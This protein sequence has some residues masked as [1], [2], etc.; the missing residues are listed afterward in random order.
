MYDICIIGAGQSGLVT[1]KTFSEQTQN[2]I[3][4]E[5]CNDCTGMF[6]T[7]KE[8]NY[9]KWSTSRSM[10]G[11]SDYPMDK[12]LPNWFTIKDYVNYLQSYK[13]HFNLD[14]HIQYNSEVLSCKQNENE[15]WIVK[16]MYNR[17]ERKL[18]CKKLI[19]CSGLNQTPKFPDI[20]KKFNGEIIHTDSVYKEMTER[21]W[22]NKF[23]GKRVLLLGGAES[24][25]DVGH[26]ITK[27]T[28][29]LYFS[30]KNYI[31][32]FPQGAES[33]YNKERKKKIKDMFLWGFDTDTPTDTNLFGVEYSLPEPVS[34]M[35]HVYGRSFYKTFIIPSTSK[36]NH[37]HKKLCEISETPDDLFKKYVVKRTD[38]I[39]DIHENK[40]KIVYY[41]DKIDG[42]TAYTKEEEIRNIDIIVCA[43]GFKK[44]FPFLDEK[45]TS[46]EFIKK[47][48]PNNTTNIAFIGFARPTMGSIAAIAEMQGWWIQSYFNQTLQYSI[49]KPWFR[50]KDP[51]NLSDEHINTLV[52]GC[53]YL[54]DLAKDLNI[55]PSM[56]YL[57]FTDFEVFKKLYAGSC[58]PMIYRITGDKYY[59]EARNTLIQT[60]PDFTEKSTFERVYFYFF[61]IFHIIFISFLFGVSYL[62]TMS[63][64]YCVKYKNKKF[65]YD[66]ISYI[67]YI[68]AMIF[69]F[70]F[71]YFF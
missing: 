52:I 23:T 1:C 42:S 31:E 18:I 30:S 40:V 8:K 53:Y 20:I 49:K 48:V 60:F 19:I 22:A 12:K 70:I 38:F 13:T 39:M 61:I 45:I 24:A 29:E 37:E 33:E 46:G 54:K 71:Y 68:L 47:M 4:L 9:F 35:W 55:E 10:S 56:S 62:M 16:F 21:D 3:V 59:P 57:F 11:F 44:Y 64:Y 41:P 15:E 51:L 66:R 36:C 26:I 17:Q 50:Y 58:H 7:I 27:Y 69:T 63:L 32:W 65:K 43:T 28:N 67:T 34:E 2:I 6:S 25:F 5:K 14:K